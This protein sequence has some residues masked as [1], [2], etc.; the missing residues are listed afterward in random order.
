MNKTPP[1]RQA[2]M[3]EP[4]PSR[5]WLE[6]AV[7]LEGEHEVSAGGS[8]PYQPGVEKSDVDLAR[9]DVQVALLTVRINHLSEHLQKNVKDSRSRQGLMAMLGERRRL[10]EHLQN[11][12][13]IQNQ[14][15]AKKIK[16]HH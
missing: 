1:G 5:R 9:A 12:G 4:T 14:K 10:L 13:L 2:T 6:K 8:I 11:T 16:L 3:N 15:L 7:E